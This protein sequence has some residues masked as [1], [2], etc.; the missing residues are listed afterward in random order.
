MTLR[1]GIAVVEG[2]L[3]P[4]AGYGLVFRD[5]TNILATVNGHTSADGSYSWDVFD[6]GSWEVWAFKDGS[7]SYKLDSYFDNPDGTRDLFFVLREPTKHQPHLR[8]DSPMG[9]PRP[10]RAQTAYNL[11]TT[12]SGW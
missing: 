3:A 1:R 2:S 9:H 7:P 8:Q 12:G 6:S 11:F 10:D 5:P 4:V